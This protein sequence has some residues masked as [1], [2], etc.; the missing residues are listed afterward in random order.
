MKGLVSPK[1]SLE[2]VSTS[3]EM[4]ILPTEVLKELTTQKTY[5]REQDLYHK[6][7][8]KGQA[9]FLSSRDVVKIA[10]RTISSDRVVS[11]GVD[12]N[13]NQCFTTRKALQAEQTLI[14]QATELANSKFFIPH[15]FTFSFEQGLKEAEIDLG[16]ALETE[17][18]EAVK[19]ATNAQ[20]LT[21]IV[22]TAGTGKST[23]FKAAKHIF[24]ARNQSIL[25]ASVSKKAADSLAESADIKAFTVDMLITQYNNGYEQLKNHSALIVDEA[26]LLTVYQLNMLFKMV[27]K[28]NTKLVLAG[29]PFQLQAIEQ[30]GAFNYL[31]KK[32]IASATELENIRRQESEMARNI[33]NQFKVGN[34]FAALK[35]LNK[36]GFVK[37]N[38]G[39]DKSVS[40]L[41]NLYFELEQKQPD[42]KRIVL[43][44]SW[45]DVKAISQFIRDELQRTGVVNE[46]VAEIDCAVSDKV[47][48]QQFAIGDRVR[49][50]KNDYSL[51]LSNGMQGTIIDMNGSVDHWVFKIQLDDKREVSISTLEYQSEDGFFPLVQ[52]YASTIYSSQGLTVDGDTLV[53]ANSYFDRANTYVAG[54]RHKQNCYWFFNSEETD[55]S[56]LDEK[57]SINIQNRLSLVSNWLKQES[58]VKLATEFLDASP[59]LT[60]PQKLHR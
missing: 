58:G 32:G 49:L 22:G 7:A 29:D 10:T 54:S 55:I 6:L 5:F 46:N 11:L 36:E 50:S 53:L 44:K 9:S 15:R 47:F 21:L 4:Y 13:N 26:S 37:F 3:A 42:K 1:R 59:K 20:K 51:K 18:L 24:L 28:S 17:Q 45:K 19:L 60:K 14:L 12:I 57:Q 48:K 38:E 16:F 23:S 41:V 52:A 27:S 33:V 30:P 56:L 39:Y 40:E 31:L 43:A 34:S 8:I 35:T 2:N 25:G